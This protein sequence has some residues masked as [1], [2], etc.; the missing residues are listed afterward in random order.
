MQ[1][2]VIA[3]RADSHADA[4][5]ARALGDADQHDIHNPNAADDQRNKSDGRQQI[6][7]RFGLLG[8]HISNLLLIAHG[9]IVLLARRD[10]VALT[11]QFNNLLLHRIEQEST[12]RLNVDAA[13]HRDALH[14]L[15]GGRVRD[16]N[17]IILVLALQR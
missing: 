13:H 11:E 15:H 12:S 17:D 6:S 8:R 10:A 3:T 14:S 16:D 9:E 4:D 7:H 1:Q 2:N 5:F